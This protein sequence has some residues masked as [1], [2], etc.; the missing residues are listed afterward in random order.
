MAGAIGLRHAIAAHGLR[1]ETSG[2]IRPSS[3]PARRNGFGALPA[4]IVVQKQRLTVGDRAITA[5]AYNGS[6]PDTLYECRAGDGVRLHFR[7]R[8][9]R[10]TNLH[11]HGLHVPPTNRADNPFLHIPPGENFTYEFQIPPNHPAGLF[12]YHPHQHGLTAEQV[13]GGLAGAWV[14]RGVLD[15]I[16]E[17]AAA[18]EEVLVLKDVAVDWRGA[19]P[20]PDAMAQM[21]GREGD[22]LTVNGRLE[23]TFT[24][25]QG[26]LLRLRFLHASASPFFR[27]RLEGHEFHLIATDGGAIA[28][29]VPLEELLL[30]PG[31]RADVL[32]NS[33]RLLV[34]YRRLVLPCDRG[35]A[36]MGMGGGMG[37]K[38]PPLRPIAPIPLQP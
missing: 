38:L 36:G 14:V 5:L 15:A 32:V 17:V 6:I 10:A 11:F 1:N 30:V 37:R 34:S 16:P 9:D 19:I 20:A 2:T 18:R 4:S 21:M 3:R 8:L 23:P 33:D 26:G 27:L 31:K 35:M 7:N 29:P 25:P 24:L 22:L 28:A 12:W 13:F